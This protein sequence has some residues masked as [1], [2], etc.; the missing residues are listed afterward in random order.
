MA[1]N[2]PPQVTATACKGSDGRVDLFHW[3]ATIMGPPDSPYE[4]GAF[5]LDIEFPTY[6]SACR[7]RVS[8]SRFTSCVS[9]ATT[10]NTRSN[11]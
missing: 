1:R 9:V 6:S 4:D 10:A 7:S 3:E 5:Q 2:P 11:Q 8:R